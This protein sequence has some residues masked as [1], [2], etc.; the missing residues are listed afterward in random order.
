MRP[1]S[2]SSSSQPRSANASTHINED[3]AKQKALE[4]QQ[5]EIDALKRELEQFEKKQRQVSQK[6]QSIILD[7]NKIQIAPEGTTDEDSGYQAWMSNLLKPFELDNSFT[8]DEPSHD[9]VDS[10]AWEETSHKTTD[11]PSE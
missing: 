4:Q 3:A 9:H 5:A 10:F 2:Q 1:S 8:L 6:R 11:G 7:L